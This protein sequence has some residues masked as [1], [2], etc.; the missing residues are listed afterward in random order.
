MNSLPV[1]LAGQSALINNSSARKIVS[2]RCLKARFSSGRHRVSLGVSERR[3]EFPFLAG[4]REHRQ[5]RNRDDEQ[6]EEQ[7]G[8][9]L[10]CAGSGGLPVIRFL[11]PMFQM[12]AFKM[13]VHV[14]D[15]HD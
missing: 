4:E 9:D 13:L 12:K 6:R 7:R 14:L 2:F 11:V 8:A 3:K 10:M 5:E 15:H 1:L